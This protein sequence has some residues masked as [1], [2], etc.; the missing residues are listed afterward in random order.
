MIRIPTKTSGSGKAPGEAKEI[1]SATPRA[2]TVQFV[3]V[4][5]R[6]RQIVLR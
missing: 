1:D 2:T 3:S 5:G 6:V 4:S